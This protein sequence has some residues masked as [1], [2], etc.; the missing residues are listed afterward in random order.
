MQSPGFR[1]KYITLEREVGCVIVRRITASPYLFRPGA[2]CKVP[3]RA[4]QLARSVVAALRNRS[5]LA[6]SSTI[7]TPLEE[8]IPGLV[9]RPRFRF[10]LSSSFRTRI[11]VRRAVWNK[12]NERQTRTVEFAFLSFSSSFP[13]L[14][15][16]PPLSHS[17]SRCKIQ[18]SKS[19]RL[20]PSR[21]I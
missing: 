4:M 3:G 5:V 21:E 2:Q 15:H 17:L 13:S 11:R 12:V 7:Y 9:S 6:R 1:R 18:H 16:F 10:I 14:P 19:Q 20:S 8:R